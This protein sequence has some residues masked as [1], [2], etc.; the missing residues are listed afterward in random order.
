MYIVFPP[1]FRTHGVFC[2]SSS[3]VFDPKQRPFTFLAQ[4]V[5]AERLAL[6]T[7]ATL[8]A[9]GDRV[10]APKTSVTF[11]SMSARCGST[12]MVQVGT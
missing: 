3:N 11:M 5:L 2:L 9:M 8:V 12:L 10:G 7:H 4:Y 1:P 6:V